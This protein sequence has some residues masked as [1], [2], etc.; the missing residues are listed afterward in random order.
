MKL[1]LSQLNELEDMLN[2]AMQDMLYGGNKEQFLTITR[3][4]RTLGLKWRKDEWNG[5]IVY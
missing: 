1:T 2:V 4:L 3:V 5:V